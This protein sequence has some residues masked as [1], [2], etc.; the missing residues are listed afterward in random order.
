MIFQDLSDL[1][2]AIIH[3]IQALASEMDAPNLKK[4]F[5]RKVAFCGGIDVQNLLV[6]RKP[7]DI[8]KKVAEFKAIFPIGL[9]ISP[10]HE[11]ILPD[12]SLANIEAMFNALK[13]YKWSFPIPFLAQDFMQLEAHRLQAVIYPTR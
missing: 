5:D 1:G 12:I 6:N 9:L 2:A 8:A 11:A 10:S 7:D 13:Q 3:P 4:N